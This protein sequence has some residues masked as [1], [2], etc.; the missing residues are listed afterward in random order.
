[1]HPDYDV[2][3]SYVGRLIGFCPLLQ[4]HSL[5]RKNLDGMIA[6]FVI[7]IGVFC[8]MVYVLLKPEKF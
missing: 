5:V 1:M 6:L 8:Y 3:N 7:A 4:S 2:F